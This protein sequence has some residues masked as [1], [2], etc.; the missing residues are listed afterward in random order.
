MAPRFFLTISLLFSFT[1]QSAFENLI[2]HRIDE[3]TRRIRAYD[4]DISSELSPIFINEDARRLRWEILRL[5]I[6]PTSNGSDLKKQLNEYRRWAKSFNQNL[7]ELS[8]KPGFSIK[9]LPQ[10]QG[11]VA[12]ELVT[13]YLIN[14][15]RLHPIKPPLIQNDDANL[16]LQNITWHNYRLAIY[17]LEKIKREEG[18]G[19]GHALGNFFA[20]TKRL[21][22]RKNT[23][24]RELAFSEGEKT[25]C[26]QLLERLNASPVF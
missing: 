3:L 7:V 23:D 9:K 12:R 2:E 8:H 24:L 18:S 13:E 10:N 14:E 5:L 16:L 15:R 17:L 26:A 25:S 6:P 11:P 19:A 4:I 21:R 20:R 22:A 1:A